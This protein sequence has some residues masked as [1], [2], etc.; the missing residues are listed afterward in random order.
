MERD[1][2]GGL[3]SVQTAASGGFRAE[4]IDG[5]WWFITPEGHPFIAV[6]FNHASTRFLTA[7]YNCAHWR[8][9]IRTDREFYDY[10]VQDIHAWNMTALGYGFYGGGHSQVP[11]VLSMRF[12]M[13]NT[14]RDEADFP[15]VFAPEYA[16]R[17]QDLA[18]ERCQPV[19]DD[20]YL[21]GY[22]YCDVPEWPLFGRASKRRAA[23]WV[24]TLKLRG[25]DSPGKRAYVDLM[26][27]R[28]DDIASFNGVYGTD[29]DS[30]DALADEGSFVYSI[31]P[32][33]DL[34]R[35]DD[36]AFLEI[37][38]RQFYEVTCSAIR[39][40]D[41]EHLLLGE[42]V[43]GN[44]GP[45]DAVLNVAAERVDVLA[46]QFYG[47]FKDQHAFLQRWHERTGLPILLADSCFA[48]VSPE[49]PRTCGVRVASQ[50]ARADAFERYARQALRMPYILG[51]FWCG[52]VDGHIE[53]EPR[54]QHTGLRDAWGRPYEPITSRMRHVYQDL[55]RIALGAS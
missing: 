48:V 54:W 38:A 26:R 16:E 49:M 10:V 25:R 8:A 18:R 27:Q 29:L 15:D 32:K 19:R 2:F 31:P 37:L 13:S 11:Y 40:V 30:F 4:Q 51:W 22:L 7:P 44:R 12:P 45:P 3:T 47:L 55:Y 35:E 17:C 41:T 43:E 42:I 34:A 36:E 24:D 39:A 1:R 28:H 52:Y 9:Q 46:V 23:N 21:I 6:G 5:R 33:P 20:P 53:I 14:W 50:E